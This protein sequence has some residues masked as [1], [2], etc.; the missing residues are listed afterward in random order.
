MSAI[1][2]SNDVPT[3]AWTGERMVPNQADPATELYH[4]QRYLYFRPWYVDKKV[5]DAASGEGYGT[6]YAAIFASEA[7]G[8]DIGADAVAHARKKYDY[9]KFALKDVCEADYSD[10]DLVTSFE[11]IEHVPDPN[12]FLDALKSCKGQIVISTPNRKTHSPGNRLE[13][14]PLNQFHTV[15]WTPSEFSDLILSH[16]P[17]RQVRFLSQEGR[18]PGLIREGLVDDAMY[19]IAVI[20]EGELPQWPRLGISIPTCNASRTQDAIL[21]FT[22][23][24]PGEIEFAIVANGCDQAHIGQLKSLQ[25]EIPHIVHLIEES[26]NL[27]YGRGANRGLDYLWQEAWFDYYVVSN[28]DV[29]PSVDFLP[30]MVTALGELKKQDLNPGV[31]GCVTNEISGSQRVDIG[32]YS[33][34]AEMQEQARLWSKEHHSGATQTVQIRG[35]FMLIDPDCL[36][37]V[38]GFDPRFGIG[39]FEDDDHNLRCLQ[40]GFTLWQVDGAFLHH[41]GSSTFKDLGID[42]TLNMDRNLNLILE[43]WDTPSFESLWT[44]PAENRNVYVPLTADVET[45]GVCIKINGEPVDLINQASNMEFAAYVMQQIQGKDREVRFAIVE[46]LKAA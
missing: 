29:Y 31:L 41:M 21:G 24:Y 33:S 6:A 38:G 14:Q 45:S 8:L 16:F 5:I 10:A 32:G 35:V 18:W 13:D 28:D 42:Y 34:I 39:N 22:K 1:A 46:A 44:L 3:L 15:E 26:E 40:A 43:K 37:K 25:N 17:T 12:K 20:G 30:Q 23:F 7:T 4:W 19:T 9:A 36:S 11:T 27:G 2:K